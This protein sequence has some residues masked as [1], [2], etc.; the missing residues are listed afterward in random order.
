M[1]INDSYLKGVYSASIRKWAV[2]R[3]EKGKEGLKKIGISLSHTG[4]DAFSKVW[5]C[6]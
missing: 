6:S 4:L 1:G 2:R 3:K 5:R